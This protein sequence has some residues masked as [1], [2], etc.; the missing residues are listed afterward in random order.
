MLQDKIKEMERE[1]PE[2]IESDTGACKFCGQMSTIRTIRAWDNEQRNEAATEIC[3]CYEAQNYV[4]KKGRKEKVYKAIE[5]KFGPAAAPDQIDETIIPVLFTI[6]DLVAEETIS[7]ATID[8]GIGIKA[9]I[10]LAS[11]GGIKVNKTKTEKQ[12]EEI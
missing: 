4:H 10:S 6:A 5:A 1:W 11:K 3:N 2:G 8:T 7:A 9:K 12:E